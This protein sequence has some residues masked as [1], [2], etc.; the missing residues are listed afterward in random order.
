MVQHIS[1]TRTD[2]QLTQNDLKRITYASCLNLFH[3]NTM[4][5]PWPLGICVVIEFRYVKR[6]NSDNYQFQSLW[7]AISLGKTSGTVIDRVDS[8]AGSVSIVTQSQ[9]QSYHKD[10]V[11][12]KDN[13]ERLLITYYY[14]KKNYS[15]NKLG[16]FILDPRVIPGRGWA[17]DLFTYNMVISLKPGLFPAK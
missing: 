6:I 5:N 8:S 4:F 7:T 16:F 9:I 12:E 3:T 13:D 15:K 10:L 1:N 17:G 14:R 11:C 2:K